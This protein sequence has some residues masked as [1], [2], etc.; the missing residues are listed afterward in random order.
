MT[1]SSERLRAAFLGLALGDALGAPF[2]GRRA[3]AG[4]EL[5]R[6][7]APRSRFAGPMTRTW[8]SGWPAP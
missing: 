1:V 4:D 2:G 3:V 8:P 6:W 5:D 7:R